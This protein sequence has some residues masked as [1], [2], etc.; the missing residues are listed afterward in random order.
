LRRK[1]N[2]KPLLSSPLPLKASPP[3]ASSGA[4]RTFISYANFVG[5]GSSINSSLNAYY[6]IFCFQGVWLGVLSI[7][8][9]EKKKKIR[10]AMTMMGMTRD[11]YLLSIWLM[12]K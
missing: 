10:M 2:N 6:V 11:P 4:G 7:L 9:V 1:A 12:Q 8:V 5:L 3:V